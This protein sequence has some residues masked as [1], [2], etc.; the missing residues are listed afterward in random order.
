M[1]LNVSSKCDIPAIY[2]EW[3]MNRLNEGYVDIKSAK[4]KKQIDRIILDKENI[5]LIIFHTKNPIPILRHIDYLKQ[6]NLLFYINV[7][8]YS[9]LIEPN[10]ESKRKIFN[11]IINL[12]RVIGSKRVIVKYEPIL[13]NDIYTIEFHVKAFTAICRILKD[14]V[15]TIIVSFININENNIKNLKGLKIKPITIETKKEIIYSFRKI[16][17][18]NNIVVKKCSCMKLEAFPCN[19]C[20]DENLA[21]SLIGHNDIVYRKSRLIP[22]YKYIKTIDIGSSNCCPNM[23]KYCVYNYDKTK[24]DKFIK[25]H[26]KTSSV[27]LGEIESDD[28]IKVSSN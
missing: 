17:R 9:K 27:L 26:D 12:S 28:N 20:L 2:L 10:Q 24:V 16:A 7:T 13:I 4:D 6:Y 19:N 3:F 23:C 11:S 15:K 8:P 18:Q 21:K 14:Y 1:I 22:G 5:D 25:N